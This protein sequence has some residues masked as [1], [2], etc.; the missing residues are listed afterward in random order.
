MLDGKAGVLKP[1]HRTF[2]KHG[3]AEKVINASPEK[4]RID[5]EYSVQFLAHAPL[6]PLNCT[7]QIKD[8]KVD[9]WVG[10]QAPTAVLWLAA[11]NVGVPEESVTCLLY[12]SRCV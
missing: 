9:V 6:E 7:A 3:D 2:G 1:L 11:G 5:A 12:T 10:N 4:Q 8:G